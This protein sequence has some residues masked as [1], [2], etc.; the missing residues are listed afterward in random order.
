M[1][2]TL[3]LSE[4]LAAE[5]LELTRLEVETAGVLLTRTVRSPDGANIRLLAWSLRLV[6]SGSYT[7]REALRLEVSSDGY[8]PALQEAEEQ[9]L[10]PIWFHTHPG[11]FADPRESE[12][13]RRVNEE[14][15]DLFRLRS[16]SE[17][18]GSVIFSTES[19][20]LIFT[21]Q[22]QKDGN[23]ALID[24]LFVVGSRFSLHLNKDV[25]VTPLP[26]IFDRNIRAFGGDLQ[27][28]LGE[29]RVAVIGCGGTGSSVAEQ[30]V[31]LGLRHL[32]L[33]D[34][35]MVSISN[36]T[37]VYGSTAA[38]IDRPK[39]HVLADHLVRI[40]PDLDVQTMKSMILIES[41]A[42]A[43][44]TADIVFGCTDDNAGR[45]VL[46]RLSTFMMIPVIDCGVILT[47]NPD[48]ELDGIHGR[49]T[50]LHP[51]A[52][53]LMCRKR[54]DIARAQS[55]MLTPEERNRLVDEG[56]APALGKTEPSV[57]AF[58]TLV[59]A[60][61]VSELLERLAAYG[62][63]PIPTEILLR[64]HEREV[65]TNLVTPRSRCY[66]DPGSGKIGFGDSSPFLGLLW[67]E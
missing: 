16:G 32:V 9:G 59:A 12:P 23:S 13:D 31:R 18:F 41:T 39:V 14:L 64:I 46:S 19:K 60:S 4:D 20:A 48:Q 5:I 44:K 3:V 7:R 62:P 30:L 49:V 15:C 65:S 52:A 22:L 61:A 28:V 55:E 33:V 25:A 66:C 6:P 37:R 24:R 8:V 50:V 40:A 38:D 63:E 1:T 42:Q 56:Y 35:D 67:Q 45:L 11:E 57:V 29:L 53:C 10:L 2:V 58:T 17:Y 47:S 26:E 36:I 34:P 43:L 27:R 21:G 54:I 51:G